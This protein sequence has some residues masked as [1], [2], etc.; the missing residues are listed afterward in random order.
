MA[1]LLTLDAGLLGCV[2]KHLPTGERLRLRSTCRH[3]ERGM[4]PFLPRTIRAVMREFGEELRLEGLESLLARYPPG[5]GP[6]E[7]HV[8]VNG[9]LSSEWTCP[10]CQGEDERLVTPE[11]VGAVL[12]ARARIEEASVRD[13][14]K[15]SNPPL[16]NLCGSRNVQGDPAFRLLSRLHHS[17]R[18]V[19]LFVADL[20]V[21]PDRWTR[22]PSPLLLHASSTA[23]AAARAWTLRDLCRLLGRSPPAES[24][25]A[26]L[27]RFSV[28]EW[29]LGRL[30][31]PSGHAPYS[32]PPV[33][34]RGSAPI[35][36]EDLPAFLDFMALGAERTRAASSE[37]ADAVHA[38]VP[39]DVVHAP[40]GAPFPLHLAIDLGV[41][42]GP[43]RSV[44]ECLR[45]RAV[46][47][48]VAALARG[49]PPLRV[50]S[51]CFYVSGIWDDELAVTYRDLLR[52]VTSGMVESPSRETSVVVRNFEMWLSPARFSV[53]YNGALLAIT[54][55]I[56]VRRGFL[57]AGSETHDRLVADC[58][59]NSLFEALAGSMPG[60]ESL[61]FHTVRDINANFLGYLRLPPSVRSVMAN[62]V[63]ADGVCPFRFMARTTAFAV[64]DRLLLRGAAGLRIVTL[65][66]YYISGRRPW[67]RTSQ[68]E[69]ARD[70]PPAP[71][72]RPESSRIL[73]EA[74]LLASG[75]G[76]EQGGDP[77]RRD[78]PFQPP[79]RSIAK[80]PR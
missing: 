36:L 16:C 53:G 43:A 69:L 1:N 47:E 60:L 57:R 63:V 75:D 56:G 48:S 39:A 9:F 19:R 5:A 45:L 58:G 74:G 71:H 62:V 61:T 42:I 76:E 50:T 24:G 6:S 33:P 54:P 46:A 20:P 14:S 64:A 78:C 49:S 37:S 51:K 2:A 26:P 55:T 72:R 70:G 11:S 41:D 32:P 34:G 40:A 59:K 38:P 73:E 13:E 4:R 44:E 18:S 3:L 29:A 12:A 15:S 66:F 27:L 7:L 77:P 21:A 80:M 79:V 67:E 8:V 68:W 52:A 30:L 31:K 10:A 65:R 17:L 23:F 28:P 25:A 35:R 22:R